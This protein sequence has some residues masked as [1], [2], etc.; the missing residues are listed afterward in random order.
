MLGL[1][2]H[3]DPPPQAG[4]GV[5]SVPSVFDGL[6]VVLW[7]VGYSSARSSIVLDSR[8]FAA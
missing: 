7:W 3:P 6:N 1:C 8:N 4:E 5:K 2:P